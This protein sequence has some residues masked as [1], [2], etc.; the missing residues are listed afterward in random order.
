MKKIFFIIAIILSG[1]VTS[2]AQTDKLNKLFQDFE[3]NGGVTSINIKKPM[4]KLLNTIDVNDAYV[5]KIKPIL[6]EVDG[7]KILI[8]PKATFPEDLEDDNVENIKLNEEKSEKVNRALKSLNFNEL[9]TM[10]NDGTSMK[11][12][13]EEE[14]DNYLENLVFNVD[15]KE[16]NIIFILNGKMKMSDVNKIINSSELK[17]NSVT[18]SVRNDLTSD[19]TSSYLNGDNRNVGEFSRIEASVGVNV[20]FK[21]E[22]NRN[23]KV[24]ADAD[25]LQYVITKVE[26]GVLKIYIDNKGQRNVRFKN[27]SI[28]VSSPHIYGVKTSSGSI[29]TVLDTV[30]ENNMD[31]EAE[32]GSVIKGNFNIKQDAAVNVSSGSVLKADLTASKLALNISSGANVNLSGQ[33]ASAVIDV[34]SGSS[35]KLEDLKIA[36]AVAESTSGA[37]L[38]LFVTDKL[39]IKVSSGAAVKLK[40]NP[41]LDA[42]VDKISGGTLRQVK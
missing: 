18:T 15:S 36:S 33:A 26:N 41:E 4:F 38:S 1:F 42:K 14:K 8:I 37:S 3:K 2:S 11:F 12:L 28:N 7:L 32:A 34:N 5:G 35:T 17:T 9:M 30:V 21:Q 40:G 22:N 6:N 20:I 10:N 39:K 25:K 29:F 27:L 13:A 19:N 16:E 23:V 31:I 24:I